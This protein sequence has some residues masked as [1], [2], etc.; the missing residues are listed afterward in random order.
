MPRSN[1]P[2]SH[3]Q[4]CGNDL[5]RLPK[6]HEGTCDIR[7]PVLIDYR[8]WKGIRRIRPIFPLTMSK[9]ANPPWHLDEEWSIGAID[10]EDGKHKFFPMKNIFGWKETT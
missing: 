9:L 7:P 6:P 3:L 1:D 2:V 5:C 10:G 8:N 4:S